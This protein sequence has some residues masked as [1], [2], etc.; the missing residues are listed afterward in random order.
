MLDARNTC[1]IIDFGL[2]A[3]KESSRLQSNDPR[4]K[5]GTGTLP[6]QA[7]ELFSRTASRNHTVDG[8]RS[9][10]FVCEQ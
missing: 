9:L 10:G 3:V 2:A 6:Y 7:P 8:E 5:A 4:I 1:K